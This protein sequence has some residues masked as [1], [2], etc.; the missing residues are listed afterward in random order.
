MYCIDC[1]ISASL[2]PLLYSHWGERGT[3]LGDNEIKL[4]GKY[5]SNL[6]KVQIMLT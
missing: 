4:Y 3:N 2:A 1:N 6:E 5:L